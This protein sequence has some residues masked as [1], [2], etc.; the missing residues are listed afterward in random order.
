MSE[1]QPIWQQLELAL[2]EPPVGRPYPAAG[3]PIRI[4]QRQHQ[5]GWPGGPRES[6][7]QVYDGSLVAV[8]P[9]DVAPR[10]DWIRQHP[11]LDRHLPL[12]VRKSKYDRLV[13]GQKGSWGKPVYYRNI[14]INPKN[15]TWRPLSEC[16]A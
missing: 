13:I 12:G 5:P 4:W 3:T 7:I 14:T 16:E 2:P 8:I 6:R 10:P 9:A 11:I 1:K 15:T